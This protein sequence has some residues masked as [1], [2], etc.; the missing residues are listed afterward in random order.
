MGIT[1]YGTGDHFRSDIT[2]GVGR[3]R[4]VWGLRSRDEIYLVQ[5][6][7]SLRSLCYNQV[8]KVWWIKCSAEDTYSHG[9]QG[10]RLVLGGTVCLLRFLHHLFGVGDIIA[11]FLRSLLIGRVG[12]L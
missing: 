1:F 2:I 11:E 12:K 7:L 5:P 9:W 8:A 6:E 4:L 10:L 3:K